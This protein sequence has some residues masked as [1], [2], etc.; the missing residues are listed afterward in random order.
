MTMFL[1][2]GNLWQ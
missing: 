2:Y 1:I